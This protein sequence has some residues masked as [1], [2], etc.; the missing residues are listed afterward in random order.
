MKNS[1]TL[2]YDG[3]FNG[4]LSAVYVA[5]EEKIN[6]ADI[7]KNGN[8]QKGLFSETKT[9]FTHVDTAKRVW[10]GIRNKSH[11]A[12]TN[13]YFSF[14]SESEGIELI[15][16][17]YIQKLVEAKT[18]SYLNYS[19]GI[20]QRVNQLA[21]SVRRE[22]QRTENLMDFQPTKDGVQFASITPE[23][24]VLPLISKHF[25]NIY[26]NQDW[27]IYDIK[28]KYGIYYNQNHV[29]MISLNLQDISFGEMGKSDSFLNRTD[30]HQ[31]FCNNDIRN[32]KIKSL[33]NG[34]LHASNTSNRNRSYS[35]VEKEAV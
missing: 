26:S 25:R 27:L 7:Q 2:I 9:I 16:Y 12:I 11:N 22:K 8:G 10:E 6:V 17:S 20:V 31:S 23:S 30:N 34:K 18:G 15:L 14:L 4:F 21:G 32:A 28:R 1:T 24:N 19:D 33:I 3:S 35:R 13:I 5:F 29:E